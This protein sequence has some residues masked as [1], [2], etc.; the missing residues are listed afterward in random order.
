[1]VKNKNILKVGKEVIKSEINALKKLQKSIGLSF[2]K[3]VELICNA[4]GNIIFTGVGKSELI[5]AKACGTFSSLGIPAY[6]LDCTA[7]AHG[8]LGKIQQKDILI[9]ASNSG[10]STEF[11]PILKFAKKN[12]I[13]I[14]GITSNNKS[15]LY[16]NSNVKVL[17][18]KVKEAGYPILPTS[19]TTLLVA[20]CDALAVAVAKKRNFT[21]T[22]FGQ[23]HP[24]GILGKS[25]TEVEKLL[26]PKSKLPFVSKNEIFSKILIKIASG[27]LGC[28]LVKKN[29][30]ISLITDGDCMRAQ[31]KFKD[32]NNIKATNIM[33]N[34][35][36]YIESNIS[37]SE[38]IKILNK[39]RITVLLVKKNNVFLGLISL[40]VL[41]E[42]L[43]K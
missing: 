37:V 5:L 36:S 32:L 24:G 15:Q 43:D 2:I 35:P 1:M 8:D 39:R 26:I 11:D 3:A 18:S 42:F 38:A 6:T 23:F 7:G 20:L 9:I 21:I 29:N 19:S 34:N 14:I 33:T 17:H 16:K 40:H 31:K 30:K 10:R 41:L 13:K 12:N 27:K 28:V 25:L 4:K 22:S